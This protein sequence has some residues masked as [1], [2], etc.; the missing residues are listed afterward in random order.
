MRRT[1]RR[2]Q[3]RKARTTCILVNLSPMLMQKAIISQSTQFIIFPYDA[4]DACDAYD[5]MH[6]SIHK[7]EGVGKER[8]SGGKGGNIGRG[9]ILLGGILIIQKEE[10]SNEGKMW[11][12]KSDE[13]TRGGRGEETTEDDWHISGKV[14]R[15]RGGRG[16]RREGGG[17][18]QH[19]LREMLGARNQSVH[20]LSFPTGVTAADTL[21]QEE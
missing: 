14:V 2:R 15:V 13:N 11:Y 16:S 1:R 12:R 4:Y 3:R 9:R 17:Y 8:E 10:M 6:L 19:P 20:A 21:L 18:G 7:E 5:M